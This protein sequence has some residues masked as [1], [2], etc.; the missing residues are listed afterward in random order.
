VPSQPAPPAV[1]LNAPPPQPAPSLPSAPDQT[2]PRE[3]SPPEVAALDPSPANERITATDE[4][5]AGR[6]ESADW[7]VRSYPGGNCFFPVRVASREDDALLGYGVEVESVQMFR[8]AFAQALGSEAEIEWRPLTDAQCTGISFARLVLGGAGPTLDIVL[9]RKELGPGVA[10]AGRV[11]GNRFDFV[12]LLV[13]DDSGVVHNVLE[14]LQ[15]GDEELVFSVPVHPVDDG[16]DRVQLIMAVGASEPLEA[17]RS[18]EPMHSDDFF[19][20][21]L[22]QARAAGASMELGLEDFVILGGPR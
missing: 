13:V 18:T 9:D 10:L 12:T 7:F 3:A 1:R 4:P 22:R 5:A 20:Q 21:V 16:A 14:Y 19:P 17:L 2:P 15:P 11:S 8:D 6:N